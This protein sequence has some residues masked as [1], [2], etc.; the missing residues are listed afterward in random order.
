MLVGGLYSFLWG[1]NKEAQIEAQ[2]KVD[3]HSSKQ[4]AHLESVVSVGS[5]PP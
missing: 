2:E 3:H 1:K 5:P 4:Q